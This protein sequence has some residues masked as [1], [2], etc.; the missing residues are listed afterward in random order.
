METRTMKTSPH[1]W[2][3]KRVVW[4]NAMS[5]CFLEH[6][7]S[8]QVLLDAKTTNS[9]VS[10]CCYSMD[11]CSPRLLPLNFNAVLFVSL[12]ASESTALSWQL[13]HHRSVDSLI[14]QLISASKCVTASFMREKQ[15]ALPALCRVLSIL[16]EVSQFKVNH[17]P[18]MLFFEGEWG[19]F[20]ALLGWV[21]AILENRIFFP[22]VRG[23]FW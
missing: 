6:L 22:K 13:I 12:S 5:E 7:P 8:F 20:S 17:V 2:G 10:G 23:L 9:S 16:P 11:W 14:S 1:W 4:H 15:G 21:S 19:Y 18:L 3:F